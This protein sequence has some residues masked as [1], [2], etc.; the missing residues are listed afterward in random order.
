[1]R[2]FSG[3]LYRALNPQ[4]AQQ[5]YSGGGARR[6]G[7]RFNSKGIAAIYAALSPDGAIRE[8]NQVGD[9]QP[10]MLVSYHCHIENVFDATDRANLEGYDVDLGSQVWRDEM[11]LHGKS[12]TQEFAERLIKEGYQALMVKSFARGAGSFD[13]NLVLWDWESKGQAALKVIDDQNRLLL[14]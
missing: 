10:T 12:K 2:S 7:G 5:P 1:M 13:V 11:R 14:V 9:L 6:F 4:W 8:V 3:K